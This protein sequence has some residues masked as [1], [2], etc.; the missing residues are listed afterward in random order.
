MSHRTFTAPR[1]ARPHRLDHPDDTA[2]ASET[3]PDQHPVRA[4]RTQH[5]PSGK[6]GLDA[7]RIDLYGDHQCLSHYARRPRDLC[8][9]I[10]RGRRAPISSSTH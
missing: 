3:P 8:Q 10:Q 2:N 9:E 6:P 7:L 5:L 4:R 1:P